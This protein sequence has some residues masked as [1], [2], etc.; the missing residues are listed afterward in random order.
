VSTI[1]GARP[2]DGASSNNN[3]GD[4]ISER[5][6]AD[7][8]A[9]WGKF[10]GASVEI[11]KLA[12]DRL[13][14][15]ADL[16]L[17]NA[18][19]RHDG[20]DLDVD[21]VGRCENGQ[22]SINFENL[23]SDREER[24]YRAIPLVWS[25]LFWNGLEVEFASINGRSFQNGCPAIS[26]ETNGDVIFTE[27]V[28]CFAAQPNDD[29]VI[30]DCA[31]SDTLDAYIVTVRGAK[32]ETSGRAQ[33]YVSLVYPDGSVSPE[34]MDL[35]GGEQA[36]APQFP[37]AIQIV[38]NVLF[39]SD[40]LPEKG[41]DDAIAVIAK[42]DVRS[43]QYLGHVELPGVIGI[44]DFAVT[45]SG[46]IFVVESAADSSVLMVSGTRV[47]E[48]SANAKRHLGTVS[49]VSVNEMGNITLTGKKSNYAVTYNHEG[50]LVAR[51]TM[52]T[53][54][55][56]RAVQLLDGSKVTSDGARGTLT[57]IDTRGVAKDIHLDAPFID[58]FSLLSDAKFALVPYTV[59]GGFGVYPLERGLAN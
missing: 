3:F 6:I 7:N 24:W 21:M 35:A 58:A 29:V 59:G 56:A 32:S 57:H 33:G 45:K 10:H 8:D 15:D 20:V 31:F 43:G 17:H 28:Q 19:A 53:E 5:A 16:A 54:G 30:D 55:V 2:S 1:C 14:I 48:F 41:G 9:Y 34:I 51:H 27:P 42:W 37:S 26:I 46:D 23:K 39:L 22:I 18:W 11:E 40:Q 36:P 44:R 4:D 49:G 38:D 12:D 50:K 13:N 25:Y 52:A 47:V